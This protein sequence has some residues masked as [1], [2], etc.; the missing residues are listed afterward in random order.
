MLFQ[1]GHQHEP[2]RTKTQN[3][4]DAQRSVSRE[5]TTNL[6]SSDPF[7]R[8]TPAVSFGRTPAL[9][10][11]ICLLIFSLLLSLALAELLVRLLLPPATRVH[12][13][14]LA[15]HDV[16]LA[17]ENATPIEVHLWRRPAD[18]NQ[19][20]YVPT[21]TGRRLRANTVSRIEKHHLGGRDIEIRTNSLGFRNPEIG[22]KR[23]PR[24]LFLGDSITFGDWLHEEETF[25]RR[26][27]EFSQAT[28][29]PLETINTGVGSVGLE[30]EIAILKEAGLETDP[31]I[32]VLDFY[33]NDTGSSRGVRPIATPPLLGWSELARHVLHLAALIRPESEDAIAEDKRLARRNHEVW[34][35]EVTARYP[36][37]PGRPLF[38]PAAMN[39]LIATNIDDWGSAWSDDAWQT[40]Q[41]AFDELVRL[42][43]V[44]GFRLAIVAFP[45]R[46]QVEARFLYDQPQQRLRQVADSLGVPLLDLLPVLRR[47]FEGTDERLFYDHCHPTALGNEIVAREILDFLLNDLS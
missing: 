21:K 5:H 27:E 17:A 8:Y 6:A 26:V 19:T 4:I 10:W 13:A 45:V 40:M 41:P 24:V 42:S 7:R 22:D 43:K 44:H 25:V 18:D 11:R 2:S 23:L 35:A 39:G 47:S 34:L 32:V 30:T 36:A 9:G 46:Y 12:V 31:D 37:G 1:H 15:E 14:S 3:P 29:M 38:K 20:L 16:R 33:L 28:E